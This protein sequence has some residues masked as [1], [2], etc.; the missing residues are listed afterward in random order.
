MESFRGEYEHEDPGK[1][2]EA[3]SKF[4]EELRLLATHLDKDDLLDFIAEECRTNPALTDAFLLKFVTDGSQ[5][6]PFDYSL[7]ISEA[8][9][10]A[11]T[12]WG[13]LEEYPI[14]EVLEKLNLRALT[15]FHNKKYQDTFQI[16]RSV[17]KD[18]P[19]VLQSL[20]DNLGI[21]SSFLLNIDILGKLLALPPEVPSVKEARAF[22]IGRLVSRDLEEFGY[23]DIIWT[24]IYGIDL[25]NDELDEL[26]KL[27][28]TSISSIQFSPQDP[29]W[30]MTDWL[31]RK[32]EL[33]KK[34]AR[35]L[36]PLEE[37]RP[38]LSFVEIR[39]MFITRELQGGR[40]E[41]AKALIQDGILKAQESEKIA[42]V[43]QYQSQLLKIATQEGDQAT[44][45]NLAGML[46]L[47]GGQ[48]D[49]EY[50][51]L[52][53]ST[54]NEIEWKVKVESLITRIG[55]GKMEVHFA[56]A[57]IIATIL[58]KEGQYER[59]LT[60][61]RD[62]TSSFELIEAHYHTLEAEFG[63]E[64]I[65]IFQVSIE[66]YAQ[67]SKGRQAYNQLVK[68]LKVM[69]KVKGAHPFVRSVIRTLKQRYPRRKAMIDILN[70][71][72]N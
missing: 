53:K 33:L 40:I 50:Y 35:V 28:D 19:A 48:F 68:M 1:M 38:Y 20:G 24:Q 60:L 18:I 36:D 10:R 30:E 55:G 8:V 45:R 2:D 7:M 29:E 65:Q 57:S 32:V 70:Q 9:Q 15:Q 43:F 47:A 6:T 26:M 17:I 56:Q 49:F 59:L 4:K 51:D 37:M 44:I 71:A 22:S 25:D 58:E 14:T 72:F 63:V 42:T 41:A 5:S 52:L 23:E 13:G 3:R 54:Y 46:F 67:N 39:D 12:E 61:L 21:E 64:I 66:E 62:N 16:C 27:I 34:D 31:L 11:E 69:G